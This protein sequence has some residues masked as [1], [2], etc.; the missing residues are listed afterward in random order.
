MTTG[1]SLAIRRIFGSLGFVV[2]GKAGAGLISLAYMVIATRILGPRDYGVLV[3]MHGFVITVCGIV[4]FPAWQ[5]IVRYGAHA[6]TENDTGRLARLLRFGAVVELGA[7]VL[8]IATIIILAPYFGPRLGWSGQALAFMPFYAFAALGAVRST[9]AAYLQLIHRFDLIG[10]HNLVAPLVRLGGSALVLLSGGGL[11]AFLVAW[12]VAGVA[13]WLSLWT[14]GY[15][16]ARRDL[17]P[18]LHLNALKGVRDENPG[19]WRFLIA[20]NGDITLSELT[21]RLAPLIV[22]WWLGPAAAGLFSVAQRVTVIIAQ[23]AQILGNSSY[24]ELA[25]MVAAGHGGETLRRTLY[26]VIGI[27]LASVAPVLLLVMF[28]STQLVTLMAGPA[29]VG[30]SGVMV[31]LVLARAVAMIGPPCSSA[32]SAMGRPGLSVRSN[33]WASLTF[34][35]LLPPMMHFWGLAGAGMQAIAQSV[36]ASAMLAV[37]TWR[38]SHRTGAAQ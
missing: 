7:G 27:A 30:A 25:R 19:I 5:G 13:E 18:E 24:A 3:L 4:S 36:A 17:G 8:A 23:P 11:Q 15:W 28:F 6:Q 1:P 38:Q 35:P 29:F 16:F 26:G 10:A 20:S 34:L 2:S 21:G 33:L 31:L 22:G 37:F 32:L 14:I 9:P 12:L